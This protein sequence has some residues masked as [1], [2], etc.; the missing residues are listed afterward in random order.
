MK[1]FLG[2][3]RGTG[4][5]TYPTIEDAVYRE[6]LIFRPHANQEI[7]QVEQKTWRIHAD[8]SETLLFWECGFLRQIEG[9]A[10]EWINAQNNG[11][12]EVL[13]GT[14][15]QRTMCWILDLHSVAF[16][17]DSRMLQSSRYFAVEGDQLRYT[18]AMAT[19]A[20]PQLET[21]LQ[22]TLTRSE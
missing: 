14:L 13:K 2:I 10:Y 15:T 11:R 9:S 3:W 16:A 17:N 5:A 8:H 22:A 12:A 20:N 4:Q 18:M 1:P 6:E 21:H 7:A 19:Q